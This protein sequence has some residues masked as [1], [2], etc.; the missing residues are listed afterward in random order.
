[1]DV[2]AQIRDGHR[3]SIDERI[4]ALRADRIEIPVGS[5]Y[6]PRTTKPG[7]SV[8]SFAGCF[9]ILWGGLLIVGRERMLRDPGT[10]WHTVVGEQMLASRQWITTDSFSFTFGGKPWIAQQWLAECAMALVHRAAGLDGLLLGAVT[11]L[12]ATFAWIFG[13]LRRAGLR[14]PM[15]IATVALVIAASSYHFLPR[16]HL[17]TIALSAWTL[18]LLAD[19]ESGRRSSRWLFVLP[20]VMVIWTNLHGGALA[21]L[22]ITAMVLTAW[23]LSAFRHR[24]E[25]SV[26]VS[27]MRCLSV[28][29]L[30]VL[31]VLVNP[32]GVEMLR[33]WLAL[34]MSSVLPRII[35]EHGPTAILGTEGLSLTALGIVYLII[36]SGCIGRKIRATWLIPLFW[37]PLAFLRV[38][39]GPIFAVTTAVAI[40]EMLPYCR[41]RERLLSRDQWD[42]R[43]PNR[44]R[45]RAPWLVGCGS[46]VAVSFALQSL[47]LHVPVVGAGWARLDSAYWPVDATNAARDYLK[48]NSTGGRVFNDLLFGGYLISE[49]PAARVYIDD[50]C[51]LYGDGFLLHYVD[52]LRN[53]EHFEQ[54]S[55]ARR[56][57]LAMVRPGS[58]MAVYLASSPAWRALHQ[59]STA[60]LFAR[61]EFTPR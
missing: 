58:R 37:L 56:I 35:N 51:E 7:L 4:A 46:V 38:R 6:G 36:L 25:R 44:G 23:T 57:D 33:V 45:R 52:L 39:H 2:T 26:A 8:R 22:A 10:L 16:P 17:V 49:L 50:R 20:P 15:A 59:D 42:V 40:A 54:E 11:I 18:S 24:H 32:Y 30:I 43:S 21:G 31:A 47:G 14:T 60:E 55:V 48:T 53:P 34:S 3:P 29:L 5:Y 27:P 13:R 19:V 1:M 28:I 41:W 61:C 9:L 12:A